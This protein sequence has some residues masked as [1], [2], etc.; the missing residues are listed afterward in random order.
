M[1][2]KQKI[3]YNND[4]QNV[5]ELI[6]RFTSLSGVVTHTGSTIIAHVFVII[7]AFYLAN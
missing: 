1:F 7:F 3:Y 4:I 5:C 2:T 6:D